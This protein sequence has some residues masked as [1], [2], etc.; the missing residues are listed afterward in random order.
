VI[1]TVGMVATGNV[2]TW[3]RVATVGTGV[4][5][6]ES[7]NRGLAWCERGNGW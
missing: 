6:G 5:G 2:G 3:Q 7:G 1:A 4:N